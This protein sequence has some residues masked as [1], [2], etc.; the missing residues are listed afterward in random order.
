MKY[1]LDAE[2]VIAAVKGRLPVVLRLGQLKPDDVA[3]SVISRSTFSVVMEMVPTDLATEVTAELEI[4][5]VGIS[6]A[7]IE[8]GEVPARVEVFPLSGN[9]R[10]KM[11]SLQHG[12]VK[13]FARKGSGQVLGGVIVAPTASELILPIAMAVTN[14]LTVNQLADS[15][16]VYPSLSGTITEAARRLVAHDDLE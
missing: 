4:A 14:Q 1:L 8:S 13:I 11:R 12:F 15:F 6:H 5:T 7:Q 3:V 16:A 10:A 2:T 9:P